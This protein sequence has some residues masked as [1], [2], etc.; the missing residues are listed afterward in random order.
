[1]K[2]L[3]LLF[4]LGFTFA[5]FINGG[6]SR[7]GYKSYSSF[8]SSSSSEEDYHH[9][10]PP[11]SPR[12]PRP[13]P[14]QP[15]PECE[16]GWTSYNRPQGTSCIKVFYASTSQST[17]ESLCRS[18]GAALTGY[19]NSN[20]RMQVS[21][22]FRDIINQNGGGTAEVWVGGRRKA[23][24]PNRNACAPL[25]TFEWI[26]GHTTGT[27]GFHWAN[28]EPNANNGPYC[29]QMIIHPT[30][31]TAG[32]K[33]GYHHGEMDGVNCGDGIGRAYACG[34]VPQ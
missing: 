12:P 4:L 6:R 9:G 24:C 3:L 1:M 17:A 20:E 31:D 29:L 16:S 25:D 22:A 8:S 14:V 21:Y 5:I 19:Q 2:L 13:Q 11:H 18:I 30:S 7:G 27:D 26:D 34:K 32:A 23:Q 10:R 33:Y 28:T 15:R